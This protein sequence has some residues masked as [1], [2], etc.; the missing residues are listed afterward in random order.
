MQEVTEN[1]ESDEDLQKSYFGSSNLLVRGLIATV[2]YVTLLLLI[3]FFGPIKNE[4]LDLNE[5]GDFLAGVFAPLAFLWLVLGFIQ[6][7]TELRQN[8]VALKLQVKE[9]AQ[10]AKHAGAMV[11]RANKE[12][13]K[14]AA[15]D[16]HTQIS[17]HQPTFSLE[18][19]NV[20]LSS[21]PGFQNTRLN[22]IN[23][24][25]EAY[26]ESIEALS[27]FNE[28]REDIKIVKTFTGSIPSGTSFDLTLKHPAQTSSGIN[29]KIHYLDHTGHDRTFE[30]KFTIESNTIVQGPVLHQK[31][32]E[33]ETLLAKAG[34]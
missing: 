3:I 11:E 20:L 24:G 15:Q 2:L 16:L 9:L 33:V 29:L 25:H 34:D 13:A 31:F 23:K 30:I 12:A 21:L 10:T 28:I 7:G 19:N 1:T 27:A 18:S 8:S 14:R 26:I 32:K 5:L 17:F 6:Q 4:P 22:L